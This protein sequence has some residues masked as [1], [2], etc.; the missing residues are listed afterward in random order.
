M[1]LFI[2]EN[3]FWIL[4]NYN[5][6][7][8]YISSGDKHYRRAFQTFTGRRKYLELYLIRNWHHRPPPGLDWPGWWV[9]DPRLGLAKISADNL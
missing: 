2:E 5:Y 6:N 8:F 3:S 1:S 7:I 4:S 9:S